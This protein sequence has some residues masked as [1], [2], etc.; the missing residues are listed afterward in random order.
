[1]EFIQIKNAH[2]NNLKNINVNIPLN[3]FTCV[4][5]CSGGGKSS[6]VFDTIYAESQRAFLE[7][8]SGNMF[9]QKLMDKPKVDSVENLRPALNVSQTY[10]NFNPRSTVGTI[11]DI[12]YYLRALFSFVS[13]VEKHKVIPENYFSANNPQNYCK[14]CKG[15]GEEYAISENALIPNREKKLKDGAILFYQGSKTSLEFKSLMAICEHYGINPEKKISELTETELYNLLYNENEIEVHLG[16][17]NYKGKYRQ[18]NVTLK[19][20]IPTL[21]EQLSYADVPS[22]YKAIAKYLRKQPCHICNGLKLKSE[23]LKIKILG[24]NISEIELLPF[25]DLLNWTT[26]VE[27]FFVN[28]IFYSEILQLT[29]QIKKRCQLINDL[30]VEYLN[31]ARTIPSLSGG[32]IQRIR[33]ANQLNCPLKDLIY[34][35]DEPCKGLHFLNVQNVINASKELVKK[36]NTVISIEHNKQYISSSENIIELGPSGGQ[37]GGYIISEKSL[38]DF[39]YRLEFKNSIQQEANFELTNINFRNIKNQNVKIPLERLTCITGV[40]GSGKSSLMSVIENCFNLKT[41]YSCETFSGFEKIKKIMVVNQKP[42]GKNPRS[43]LATYLEIYD[44]I[45]DVF[46]STE[47]S[48]KRGL[49][50]SNFSINVA[51]GRCECCQ[52]TGIQKIELN[53]LPDSYI[54][55]PICKG[56]R[57]EDK[58][59]EVHYKDKNISEILDSAIEDITDL[60]TES[61]KIY[62]TLKCMINIGLG[63]LSLG[64][65]SM[66]LS[67]GEAQRIKIV[68]ALSFGNTKNSLFL[69]DEPTSGLGDSDIQMLE[70]KLLDLVTNKNTVIIVE[71]NPE[72]IAKIA[73]YVIDFGIFGGDKGGIISAV[74]RPKEVFN[75]PKS[76][77]FKFGN[78]FL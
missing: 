57:F 34:I 68:K 58:I 38:C 77:W 45:R 31:C 65:T 20:L 15:T 1:M 16:F 54:L 36:G 73:D 18:K 50:S 71:H 56:K 35:L 26:D 14:N 60:F 49:G 33:I 46:S 3:T 2:E 64:R 55:C 7:S 69:L 24:K 42:I 76:S 59:L 12:S 21:N 23:I 19:G 37:K 70:K 63:Y 40:S 72:F 44:F 11:T 67:G 10:Y 25:L 78:L 32:E 47:E 17:K 52:G 28:A 27:N 4:T 74:G 39:K 22:T 30:N 62:D 8:M 75:N 61:P 29:E 13:S 48:K 51:A 5:G 53:F 9:G 41:N 43:T 6:L 66:S